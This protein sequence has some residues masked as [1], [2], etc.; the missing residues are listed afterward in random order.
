MT[1]K[2]TQSKSGTPR[3]VSKNPVNKAG[4]PDHP[5]LIDG[6]SEAGKVGTV[7]TYIPRTVSNNPVSKGGRSS[8]MGP[9][10]GVA[11]EPT[12]NRITTSNA[13]AFVRATGHSVNEANQMGTPRLKGGK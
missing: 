1:L 4:R 12:S 3:S 2:P 8:G 5:S 10:A 13:R 6:K 9:E 11:G 7:S